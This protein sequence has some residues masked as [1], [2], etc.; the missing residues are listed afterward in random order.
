MRKYDVVFLDAQGT[1]LRAHPSVPAIYAEVCRR[2][3]KVVSHR[4]VGEAIRELWIEFRRSQEGQTAAFD[5]SD[6]ATREW[7]AAFNTRVFHRLGMRENL[8]RFLEGLWEVFGQAQNWR[9]YPEVQEVLAELRG[10]NYRLGVVSNW[11]SRL[12]SICESL[13][14]TGHVDFILAS[15][16]TGMEKPDRRIFE[17]ALARAAVP[18]HRAIH[19]GDDYEADVLGARGA[20]IDALLI[21][22]DGTSPADGPTIRSLRELLRILT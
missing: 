19:V 9:L 2:S 15:A 10:R 20:G 17:I 13:G 14:L 16:A 3:G 4:Q 7:W 22:R 18:P 21:D 6:E 12:V 8:D 11:D 1:L 5:T